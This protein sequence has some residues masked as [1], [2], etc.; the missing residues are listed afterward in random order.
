[1]TIAKTLWSPTE[2]IRKP[3]LKKRT[4]EQRVLK[5][6]SIDDVSSLDVLDSVVADGI[7]I[8]TLPPYEIYEPENYKDG[9]EGFIR[10]VEDNVS[11]PIY[12]E[13]NDIAVWTPVK[14]LPKELSTE[15][16]RSYW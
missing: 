4:K 5:G 6:K 11:I 16:G 1:M 2:G 9:P 7:D 3:V 14:D 15:T 10:W 12:P 13:G 8:D